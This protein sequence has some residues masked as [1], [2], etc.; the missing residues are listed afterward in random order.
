MVK[1]K[2]MNEEYEDGLNHIVCEECG[3]CITCGDCN[4]YGCGS[5]KN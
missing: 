2:T 5:H 4:K 3:F 1:E